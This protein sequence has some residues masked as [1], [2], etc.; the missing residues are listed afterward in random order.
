M[1][2]LIVPEIMENLILPDYF[3]PKD[4]FGFGRPSLLQVVYCKPVDFNITKARKELSDWFGVSENVHDINL[5]FRRVF[6]SFI[7]L[8]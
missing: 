8:S 4:S 2:L 3:C 1:Q 5:S 7:G 6:P